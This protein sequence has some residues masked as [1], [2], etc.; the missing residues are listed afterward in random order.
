MGQQEIIIALKRSGNNSESA[1]E[2]CPVHLVCL[3]YLVQPNNETNQRN[4]INLFS[5][6]LESSRDVGLRDT[7]IPNPIPANVGLRLFHEGDE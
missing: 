6:L 7:S 3:V 4:Q 1:E 5:M 2:V